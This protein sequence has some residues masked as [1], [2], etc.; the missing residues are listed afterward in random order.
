MGEIKVIL[1]DIDGTLL[2]F[3]ESEKVSIRKCF[4]MFGLGECTDEMLHAYSGIN[5]SYWERLE[6]GEI[7]KPE[8]LE[9][10]FLDFFA[11]YHIE[12]S[13]AEFNREYQ[14]LL[15]DTACFCPNGKESVTACRGKVKQYAVTNG[16]KMAQEKKLKNS[17]LSDL[18][19]GVFIS[20]DIGV[21]KPATG[22]FEE[23]FRKI[24]DYK[25]SEVLIV[26][27]SLTSDMLGGNTMGIVTC[28][29]NPAGKEKNVPVKIDHEITDLQQVL[30]LLE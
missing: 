27:D 15:G 9:G 13:A 25:R 29:Y 12:I 7:T 5:R 10:R 17:G 11:R 28:W 30:G 8:V 20:E 4:R 23:V 21:E 2:N 19:D 18:L 24:G 1:W 26:G 6:R 16:T 14:L 22:F 3:E